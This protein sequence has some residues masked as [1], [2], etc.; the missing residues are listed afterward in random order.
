[1]RD[2]MKQIFFKNMQGLGIISLCDTG[3]PLFPAVL[4]FLNLLKKNYPLD[5]FRYTGPNRYI[6]QSKTTVLKQMCLKSLL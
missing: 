5:Y 1:M 4:C 3:V 2:V 6:S